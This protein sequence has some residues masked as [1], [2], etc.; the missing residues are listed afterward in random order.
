MAF[1]YTIFGSNSTFRSARHPHIAIENNAIENNAAKN[2]PVNAAFWFPGSAWEP[3][4][5]QALPAEM[6][7]DR[8]RREAEPTAL[9]IFICILTNENTGW[10]GEAPAEVFAAVN[11]VPLACG[12]PVASR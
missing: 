11:T 5:P 2:N 9:S 1:A 8:W 10:E 3:N 4:E 12:R 6:S 7:L